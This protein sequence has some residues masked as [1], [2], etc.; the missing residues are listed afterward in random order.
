MH[1]SQPPSEH[2]AR[3]PNGTAI[4]RTHYLGPHPIIHFYLE[5]MNFAGIISGC[6]GTGS[7]EGVEGL[8]THDQALEVLVHNILVAPSPLYRIADWVAP[9]EGSALGLTEAQKGAVNDDRI[10]RALDALAGQRGRS[11]FFRLALRVLKEFA[12]DTRR[13]HYDTTSVTLSGEYKTSVSEPAIRNG[14]NKDHRPDLKQLVFGLNVT[15]DGAVALSHN[16]YSGNKTDDSVHTSNIETLRRILAREDF[17]YVADC[18]LCTTKN[19]S[20]LAEA[21]GKFVTVLPRS[22]KEDKQFRTF[23][24]DHGVHW[25]FLVKIPS[26]RRFSDPP[27]IYYT[28]KSPYDKSAEGHRLI[29]LRSSEKTKLD[30]SQRLRDI[31]SALGALD[32]LSNKLN[33]GKYKTRAAVKRAAASILLDHGASDFIHV[34]VRSRTVLHTHFE[35]PGRPKAGDHVTT[36]RSSILHI[37]TTIDKARVDKEARTDGV[38]P[39][40][41]NLPPSYGKREILE[42]YKDQAFLEKRF[43]TLKSELVISP[44][45]LKKPAR[46]VGLLH[47]YFLAICL[48]SLIERTVRLNMKAQAVQ[49]LPLLPEHRP[50]ESPTYP[51]IL[52][53]FSPLSWHQFQQADNVVTFPLKLDALQAQVLRLIEVPPYV[54]D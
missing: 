48:A 54:Y 10:A 34:R 6:L 11:V 47:V 1:T 44:V 20:N 35:R 21:G 12:L 27:D 40:I 8:L 50:S 28:C 52:E 16:V 7:M 39:I 37:E 5:R 13:V 25:N 4:L 36:S 30:S 24:R 43:S 26:R 14:V 19:L 9:I 23:V 18:K 38:F 42:I 22:R 32:D 3:T 33:R 53:A 2:R 15:A 31:Q 17:I 45:F 49:Y 41:T 51:R 29:W 46:V